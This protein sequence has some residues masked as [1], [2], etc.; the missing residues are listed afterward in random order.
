MHPSLSIHVQYG[1]EFNNMYT[2]KSADK[3][4]IEAAFKKGPDE[5]GCYMV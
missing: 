4:V 1:D 5:K 3:K 2:L